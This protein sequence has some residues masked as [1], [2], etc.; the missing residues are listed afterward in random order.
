MLARNDAMTQPATAKPEFCV[1]MQLSHAGPGAH[2]IQDNK[3]SQLLPLINDGG[4]I[5][6]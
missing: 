2:F 6:C 1:H 3:L 4:K 5:Y